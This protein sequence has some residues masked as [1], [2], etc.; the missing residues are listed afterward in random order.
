MF[1]I[2]LLCSKTSPDERMPTTVVVNEINAVRDT[3]LKFKK[4]N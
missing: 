3:Y 4:E 1:E 2:G